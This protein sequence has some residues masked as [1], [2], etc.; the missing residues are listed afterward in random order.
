MF[1]SSDPSELKH[2]YEVDAARL[3][4]VLRDCTRGPIDMARQVR[5]MSRMLYKVRGE[6]SKIYRHYSH[7]GTDGGSG[8]AL[9]SNEFWRFVKDTKVAEKNDASAT[10]ID[11]VFSYATSYDK[12]DTDS[13]FR[14][15]LK[16]P[17]WISCLIRIAAKKFWRA[18]PPKPKA[19]SAAP[20]D[21]IS[22][23]TS[24][25][26]R[27]VS[28]AKA[29]GMLLNLHILPFAARTDADKFRHELTVPEVRA[30]WHWASDSRAVDHCCGAV[31]LWYCAVICGA[32]VRVVSFCEHSCERCLSSTAKTSCVCLRTMRNRICQR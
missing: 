12:R 30:A 2:F 10:H 21:D 23:A 9:T 13:V 26:R 28:L 11:L 20:G 5:R 18:A 14:R 6:L 24:Q 25:R 27:G 4:D 3:R 7:S 8:V 31:V 15:E 29:L 22:T 17:A 16:P 32:Y 1:T 19:R